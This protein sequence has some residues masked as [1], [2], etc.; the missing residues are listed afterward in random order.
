MLQDLTPFVPVHQR[1]HR[2]LYRIPASDFWFLLLPAQLS[3]QLSQDL[4]AIQGFGEGFRTSITVLSPIR[5][6]LCFRNDLASS[7][8][9]GRRH[10]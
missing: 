10:F 7:G 1:R 4:S 6:L 3:L 8:R 5:A 9:D 2:S